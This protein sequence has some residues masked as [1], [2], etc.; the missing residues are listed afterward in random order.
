MWWSRTGTGTTDSQTDPPTPRLHRHGRLGIPDRTPVGSRFGLPDVSCRR[1]DGLPRLEHARRGRD[2]RDHRIVRLQPPWNCAVPHRIAG[3][4]TTQRNTSIRRS[5]VCRV[6]PARRVGRH[7]LAAAAHPHQRGLGRRHLGRPRHGRLEHVARAGTPRLRG[8]LGAR[9]RERRRCARGGRLASLKEARPA[10]VITAD[11]A[12]SPCAGAAG[13][14][15]L[16]GGAVCVR[17]GDHVVVGQRFW[18]AQHANTTTATAALVRRSL[19][20]LPVRPRRRSREPLRCNVS[21][22]DS[23]PNPTR[24]CCR[25]VRDRSMSV[26]MMRRATPGS[27]PV[28]TPGTTRLPL[29]DSVCIPDRTRD[30]SLRTHV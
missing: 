9:P 6:R 15:F 2:V 28:T 22:G 18:S 7:G 4:L 30:R 11:P 29:C 5:P 26:R 10:V 3:V 20:A 14:A 24:P 27:A 19:D 1:F 13:D 25:S 17:L 16:E 23:Y 8:G 21:E 12:P